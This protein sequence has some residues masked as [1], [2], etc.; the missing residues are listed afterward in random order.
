[1]PAPTTAQ[2]G[3]LLASYES[4]TDAQ[5]A[6]DHLSDQ[7][8]PVEHT[9]IVG[10]NLKLVETVQGRMNYGKAAASGAGSGAWFGLLVGL[11]FALFTVGA[12]TWLAY[13]LGG[14]VFGA[15]FG[16]VFGV[17]AY[18]ATR[19]R[20]D[21]ESQS[22]LVASHYDVMVDNRYADQARE[23]LDGASRNSQTE[24]ASAG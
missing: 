10:S 15:V 1:M 16:A 12:Y 6:V 20:R 23:M 22:R 13:L 14:L 5:W 7:H 4:Y 21:F 8:F 9:A 11:L 17:G 18:A 2:D 24:P 19:G 3:T